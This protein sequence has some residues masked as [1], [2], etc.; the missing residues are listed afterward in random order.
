M[1]YSHTCGL[2]AIPTNLVSISSYLR[3]HLQQDAMDGPLTD[4]E[5][6][7]SDPES[8]SYPSNRDREACPSGGEGPPAG[9][10][11]SRKRR[12]HRRSNR[13]E[14]RQRI[15]ETEGG[16][17]KGISR[18]RQMEG[19]GEAIQLLY[20]LGDKA[21]VSLSGWISMHGVVPPLENP[22][23]QELVNSENLT[24]FPWDGWCVLPCETIRITA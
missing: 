15:R 20:C 2:R 4:Y 23:L 17:L 9:P 8:D 11:P 1:I 7:D 6:F 24:Y 19:A 12:E 14:K 18:R 3:S 13:R 10:P 5:S 21:C 16:G 22:S